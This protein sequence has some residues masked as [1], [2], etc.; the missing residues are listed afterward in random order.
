MPAHNRLLT[1]V[2]VLPIR[3]SG[4]L[5]H[6]VAQIAQQSKNCVQS[7]HTHYTIKF[8]Y[9][10]STLTQWTPLQP[11]VAIYLQTFIVSIK[12]YFTYYIEVL[13][14]VCYKMITKNS[15][16]FQ[17]PSLYTGTSVNVLMYLQAQNS[18]IVTF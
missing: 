2:P 10:T 5:V 6:Q 12:I 1:P 11:G 14:I 3:S 9:S 8:S 7:I 15:R 18:R 17:T 13:C 16:S 4:P